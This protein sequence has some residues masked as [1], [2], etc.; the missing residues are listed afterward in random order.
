MIKLNKKQTR[1]CFIIKTK[2]EQEVNRKLCSLIARLCVN[3][4]NPL[5]TVVPVYSY[6]L[7]KPSEY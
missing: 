2:S 3:S 1:A 7:S 4:P 5:L 6:P